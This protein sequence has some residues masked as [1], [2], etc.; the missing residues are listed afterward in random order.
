MLLCFVSMAG[1]MLGAQ[2]ALAASAA[3]KE[4]AGILVH[5][6]HHPSDMEK[7]RLKAVAD[8]GTST[9]QESVLARAISHLQHHAA[10]EDKGKLKQIMDDAAAPAEV[11]ELAG[12]IL[13]LSHMPSAADKQKLEQMMK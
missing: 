1:L 7:A 9:D 3:V 4:M 6:E 13:N 2:S 5:L 12:I 11:K 8:N 10:D